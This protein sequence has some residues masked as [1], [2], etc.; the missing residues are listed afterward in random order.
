MKKQLIILIILS[1]AY[2]SILGQSYNPNS[3]D[4]NG[5][6]LK[7][8]NH[9]LKKVNIFNLGVYCF[10][11]KVYPR[12]ELE[13]Y[14]KFQSGLGIWSFVR[15]SQAVVKD[16]W[17][18]KGYNLPNYYNIGI[19][20]ALS[21]DFAGPSYSWIKT[22]IGLSYQSGQM[23][24]GPVA[25]IY[26]NKDKFEFKAFGVY[27]IISAYKDSYSQEYANNDSSHG[28]LIYI[29]DFDPNSW[30]RLSI[31][32]KLSKRFSLGLQSERFYGTNLLARYDLKKSWRDL[33]RLYLKALSGRD[34]E[35]KHNTFFIGL[36]LVL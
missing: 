32:Y 10:G 20:V 1:F 29:D 30:Y 6:Y 8:N 16:E 21:Y 27:S 13:A 15:Y 19:N 26:I 31:L 33:N 23:Y 9:Q 34:F 12:G 17:R 2:I 25:G 28:E 35:F 3:Y 4:E 36:V 22:F 11:D 5:R 24:F 7:E 14:S 18:N